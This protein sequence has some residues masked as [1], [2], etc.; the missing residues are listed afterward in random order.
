MCGCNRNKKSSRTQSNAKTN[1]TT[2]SKNEITPRFT[3]QSTNQTRSA[4]GLGNEKRKI[5][6]LRRDAIFNNLG[7]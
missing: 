7:K 3:A 6:K 5:E 4:S 1:F 2:S